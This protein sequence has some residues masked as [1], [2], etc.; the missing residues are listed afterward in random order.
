[1]NLLT[2]EEWNKYFSLIKNPHVLQSYEWGELKS[3]FGWYP[4]RINIGEK[5][6]QIL[7]RKLP[8]GFSIGYIP[9]INLDKMDKNLWS[10][11]DTICK[12][13]RSIF[14]KFEPDQFYNPQTNVEMDSSFQESKAIQPARTIIVDISGSE[15]EW[16]QRMKSKTRYN[17]KLA[18]KKEIKVLLSDDIDTFYQLMLETGDRDKFGVHSKK[19]YQLAFQLF[20]SSKNVALLLAYYKDEPLAGLMV[21]KSGTRSWYFYGASNNKERNRM[22]T[23]LLQ[24]EA[25][26]WAKTQGCTSYDLWG[27]P[28]EEEKVLE[29]EFDKRSDGLWGVY[30]FKRGFGGEIV[31]S[32]PALDRVYNPLLY[33]AI[34]WYQKF[35]G[36]FL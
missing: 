24:F 9:K 28:D 8:L 5:P 29:S 3:Y 15:D 18:I 34:S 21:F 30:R 25:M 27:I 33:N 19:Y 6:I 10:E 13:Q 1:M 32:A 2:N 36:S 35:R 7:F 14:L 26:K 17:I 12:T 22:P 16:L 20:N 31:R 11:I 4:Y 23:Y